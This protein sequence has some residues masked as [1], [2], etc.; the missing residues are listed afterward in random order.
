MYCEEEREERWRK[1]KPREE[2]CYWDVKEAISI[3]WPG[4]RV[5]GAG[6]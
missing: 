2:P 5:E 1:A 4:L 6:L 3:L